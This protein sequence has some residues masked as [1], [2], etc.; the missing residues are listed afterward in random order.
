LALGTKQAAASRC[1]NYA[2]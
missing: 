2:V 1:Q